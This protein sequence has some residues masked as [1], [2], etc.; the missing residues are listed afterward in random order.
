MTMIVGLKVLMYCHRRLTSEALVRSIPVTKSMF[1]PHAMPR[2]THIRVT[3]ASPPNI[4]RTSTCLPPLLAAKTLFNQKLLDE[5]V[6][7]VSA[8]SWLRY[9]VESDETSTLPSKA[10]ICSPIP[11]A[12]ALASDQLQSPE[13]TRSL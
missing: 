6:C 3:P 12:T 9:P 2:R 10:A 11:S 13:S 4:S 7:V 8:G 1:L 5:Y